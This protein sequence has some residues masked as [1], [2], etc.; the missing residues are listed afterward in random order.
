MKYLIFFLLVFS[1]I[2]SSK[3]ENHGKIKTIQVYVALCD[4]EN[5]GIV[6]VPAKLGNGKDPGNNLYWGAAYG[7]KS[8]FK[9]SKDWK[10]VKTVKN[11]KRN[12]LERIVFKNKSTETYL[13]ADAYDG[14]KIKPAIIDFL[15]ASAG[16]NM[17]TIS[18]DTLKSKIKFGGAADLI[19]YIGH[20]G[21]MDF[22]L[23]ESPKQKNSTPRGII[24]L[25][26]YSKLYFKNPIKKTGANPLI[27]TSGLMAPEAYTLEWALKGWLLGESAE[28]IRL[29]AARAY[30][31]YQ[32]CGLKRARNL[33]LTGW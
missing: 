13:L 28:Q 18:I 7:V 24:I 8:Y 23:S 2:A 15:N 21:L 33:L 1:F 27:W 26:C 11:P 22:S 20:N 9:K 14:A 6:K 3:T 31:H 12:V 10:L 25:A 29:R 17:E 30:N 19:V 16:D 4:N 32:K 5:Q